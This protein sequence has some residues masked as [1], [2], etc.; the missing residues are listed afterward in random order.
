MIDCLGP[1]RLGPNDDENCGIYTGDAEEL[2]RAIPDRSVDLVFTDPPYPYKYIHTFSSLAKLSRRVLSSDG[3]V[4]CYS[5]QTYLPEVIARL[6]EHL[7]YRWT[8][9]V[10]H[11]SSQI[12]WGARAIAGWKPI[13]VLS[14]R[15]TSTKD[16]IIHDVVM[17]SHRDKRFHAWGQSDY[18]AI[19]YIDKLTSEEDIVLDPFA[20]GGTIPAACK[21]LGRRYLAFEIGP[22]VAEDARER[23]RKMQ[24]PLFV[25]EIEQMG[26]PYE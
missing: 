16:T 19:K 13:F 26:M 18:E 14:A 3:L 10:M 1:Y 5:G 21:V 2:A 9:A 23:V 4:L 11:G 24:P 25:S 15:A 12:V 8:I 7:H 20:G 17:P 6:C 22:D